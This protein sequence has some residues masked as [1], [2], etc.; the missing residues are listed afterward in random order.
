MDRGM[1]PI[2][3]GGG[4]FLPYHRFTRSPLQK[5]R[6]LIAGLIKGNQRFISPDHEVFFPGP[7]AYVIGGQVE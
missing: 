5:V 6:V 4:D 2:M 7:G 3:A 1:G